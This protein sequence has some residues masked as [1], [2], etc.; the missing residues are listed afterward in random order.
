MRHLGGLID[1]MK[2]G[3]RF[4]LPILVISAA[5]SCTISAFA[6][7]S[8]SGPVH[9]PHLSEQYPDSSSGTLVYS[10][11]FSDQTSGWK[12]SSSPTESFAY[13]DGKYRITAK[14]PDTVSLAYIPG[15]QIFD[16]FTVEV[17]IS[18][19]QFK[20]GEETQNAAGLELRSTEDGDCYY[21][22]IEP[23]G[24]YVFRKYINERNENIIDWAE[25]DAINIGV[26]TNTLKI[27]CIGDEFTFYINGVEIG[28]CIDSSLSSGEIG[29][30][31]E[32]WDS[33][34]L[35]ASF[36]NLKVWDMPN[37]SFPSNKTDTGIAKLGV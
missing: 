25:S 22:M 28:R 19:D 13:E 2:S 11:D 32:T 33:S 35:V 5:L 4:W 15:N 23:Y 30:F 20:L 17:D 8:F 26:A 7:D 24:D 10:D 36:D 31:A 16:D 34:G 6:A 3:Y 37:A 21:F 18:F 12:R 9:N 29:L 27:V 1:M 14:E